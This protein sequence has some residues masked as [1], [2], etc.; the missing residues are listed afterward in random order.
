M[1]L[2]TCVYHFFFNFYMLVRDY[3][4][5]YFTVVTRGE[6]RK[7]LIKTRVFSIIVDII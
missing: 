3:I 6:I 4:I 5:F 2:G 1:F 7:E